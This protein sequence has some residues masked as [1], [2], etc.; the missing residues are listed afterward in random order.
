MNGGDLGG[1]GLR[2]GKYAIDEIYQGDCAVCMA[3][4]PDGCIDLT[5]TSPPY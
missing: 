2:L 1:E 4:L 5:V 3:Q